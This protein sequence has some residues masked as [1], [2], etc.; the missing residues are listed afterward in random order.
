MATEKT[1]KFEELT[2]LATDFVTAQKGLWDHAAW[3]DFLSRVRKKGI[4]ISDEMQSSLGEMLEAMKGFYSAAASTESMEKA[5][6][7]V[8]N[9]SVAFVK[10]HKGVWSH[11]DWEDFLKTARQ[12]TVSVTEGTK[13]YLGGVLESMKVFYGAL[14]VAGVQKRIASAGAKSSPAPKTALSTGK[15]VEPKPAAAKPSPKVAN[16]P[17][18]LTVIGGIG[19]ALAKKLV[20]AGISTYAQLAALSDADIEHLEKD[21]IKFSG[22]IKRDDWIGQ[23][24]KLSQTK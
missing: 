20:S 19:P 7:T 3:T 2:K 6:K 10:D 8:V 9:D 13:G 16:K 4:D 14:P 12:N 18:D 11:S 17:D 24:K 22:R 23:A 5:M 15:K 21:I 1:A